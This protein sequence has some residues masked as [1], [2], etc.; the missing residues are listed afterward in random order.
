MIKVFVD[1]NIIIDLLAERRPFIK[2]AVDLFLLEESHQIQLYTSSHSICTIHYLLKKYME[3]KTLREV[4]LKLL[5]KM[6]VV[7]VDIDILKMG[8]RS[9]HRDF[10][11]SIQ[12]YSASRIENIKC[13]VTRNIKDYKHSEIP[14]YSLDDFFNVYKFSK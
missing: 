8:L 11:D 3:E 4:I 2:L 12:I 14:T 13:I 10:E 7:P 6:Q 5:N 1:T 9:I